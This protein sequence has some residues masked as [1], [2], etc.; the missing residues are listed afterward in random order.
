MTFLRDLAW[1][2]LKLQYRSSVAHQFARYAL[3]LDYNLLT[4]DVVHQAKRCLLDPRDTSCPQGGR[5]SDIQP[6]PQRMLRHRC[7]SRGLASYPCRPN[8]GNAG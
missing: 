8:R 5:I 6:S 1:Q 3:G 2:N 4:P 7:T